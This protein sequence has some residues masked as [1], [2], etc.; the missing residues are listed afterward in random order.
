[1]RTTWSPSTSEALR[2]F[3]ILRAAVLICC[4][5]RFSLSTISPFGVLFTMVSEKLSAR[6]FK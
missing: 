4:T 1:M 6:S 5:S 3:R 2:M